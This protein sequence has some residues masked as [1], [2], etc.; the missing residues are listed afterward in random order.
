VPR[1]TPRNARYEPTG[2]ERVHH[3]RLIA[4]LPGADCTYIDASGKEVTHRMS[5]NWDGANVAGNYNQL[6]R[7]IRDG[8]VEI[9]I[10]AIVSGGIKHSRSRLNLND[11]QIHTLLNKIHTKDWK[12]LWEQLNRME[13]REIAALVTYLWPPRERADVR[14]GEADEFKGWFEKLRGKHTTLSFVGKRNKQGQVIDMPKNAVGV[15]YAVMMGRGAGKESKHG[16][17]WGE[18]DAKGRL[19]P[20]DESTATKDK[21]YE[22]SA[23]AVFEPKV[24][25]RNT[26]AK[27]NTALFGHLMNAYKEL[28]SAFSNQEGKMG[29]NPK[30]RAHAQ[31]AY[32]II[33]GI[34]PSDF[35]RLSN[36][37][38]TMGKILDTSSGPQQSA[39]VATADMLKRVQTWREEGRWEDVFTDVN[40]FR[41][42]EKQTL[43]GAGKAKGE[44]EGDFSDTRTLASDY[45]MQ[46]TGLVEDGG[47]YAEGRGREA[48]GE[49]AGGAELEATSENV[50]TRLARNARERESGSQAG[51]D[52]AIAVLDRALELADQNPK[53]LARNTASKR[54]SDADVF[55]LI[56]LIRENPSGENWTK[57]TRQ[58]AGDLV[59]AIASKTAEFGESM[60]G[61]RERHPGRSYVMGIPGMLKAGKGTH[62]VGTPKTPQES[63]RPKMYDILSGKERREVTPEERAELDEGYEAYTRAGKGSKE[64]RTSQRLISST[65]YTPGT[66]KF[67]KDQI[68]KLHESTK[69][70]TKVMTTEAQTK[71]KALMRVAA[72]IEKTKALLTS[73]GGKV[74]VST[75]KKKGGKK[76]GSGKYRMPMGVDA[77]GSVMYSGERRGL[78]NLMNYH[79]ARIKAAKGD[80]DRVTKRNEYARAMDQW[81]ED[82]M[83]VREEVLLLQRRAYAVVAKTEQAPRGISEQVDLVTKR[84]VTEEEAVER[85]AIAESEEVV[86]EGAGVETPPPPSGEWAI[87]PE[88]IHLGN[89]VPKVKY[90][91]EGNI[92]DVTMEHGK[93]NSGDMKWAYVIFT[94]GRKG[95]LD[96]DK[97]LLE[98]KDAILAGEPLAP[99][100]VELRVTSQYGEKGAQKEVFDRLTDWDG[101]RRIA[102]DALS[103]RM[104]GTEEIAGI[105]EGTG[106][107]Q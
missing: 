53:A 76:L 67:V 94:D 27:S 39:Y 78:G 91:A 103:K 71:I 85:A 82:A 15:A 24:K 23:V 41:G 102:S 37:A 3:E 42:L 62:D 35:Q 12:G 55:E 61:I 26:P 29:A 92:A 4:Q 68:I 13:T 9:P 49:A 88:R 52:R 64:S 65:D 54:V 43:G 60:S 20:V 8:D 2:P 97:I 83:A 93:N 31:K 40:P 30:S 75:H 100:I 28:V 25:P 59:L 89:R 63:T 44:G 47:V 51:Y 99:D 101:V 16:A 84:V 5:D 6:K 21:G 86:V 98:K 72:E 57:E 87:P 48:A 10:D 90:D 45:G 33:A 70:A 19:K 46:D 36:W 81:R 96:L 14:L 79:K 18:K 80:A 107:E 104:E 38:D 50:Y 56:E 17:L 77:E 22:K 69:G 1:H 105:D 106:E 58:R 11:K 73:L 74:E 34:H 7:I 95:W 32:N 66:L